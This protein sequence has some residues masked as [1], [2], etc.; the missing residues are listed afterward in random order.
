ML[1]KEAE[2]LS[3]SHKQKK[4]PPPLCSPFHFAG[5]Q[6]GRGS[7]NRAAELGLPSAAHP[8]QPWGRA[9]RAAPHKGASSH[10]AGCGAA[11][12]APRRLPPPPRGRAGAQAATGKGSEEVPRRRPS[13]PPFAARAAL[14]GRL[15]VAGTPAR[16]AARTPGARGRR[17]HRLN[18]GTSGAR[19]LPASRRALRGRWNAEPSAD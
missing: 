15:L 18:A 1:R 7:E 14:T 19:R 13:H 4:S 17:E 6:P 10:R 16:P 5:L 11:N 12:S 8:L 3:D 2:K 9:F